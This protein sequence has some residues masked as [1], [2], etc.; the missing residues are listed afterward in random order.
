MAV[1][2]LAGMLCQVTWALAG[3]TGRISGTV[4]SADT[5]APLSNVRVV[6]SSPSQTTTTASDAS[7]TF[8]FLSLTPD[9]YTVSVQKEGYQA[10]SQSG[11]VVF[12]DATQTL[13]MRMQKE[14]QTIAHVVSQAAG[15]LVKS[16]TTADVYSINA[17]MQD[18]ISGLGGGG[19]LNSAYSAIASVPGAFVPLNQMGYFQTVHIRGGDYDQVGYELDGIPVNRSFDNYP[20]GAASSLGQQ[21]LQVYTGASPANSEGQGLAGYINQVIKSGT[22]PGFGNVMLGVGGP[23]FYHKLAVEAGGAAP[24]RLFSYYVGVGGYNQDFRYVDQNNGAGLVDEAGANAPVAAGKGSCAAILAPTGC[25]SILP[26]QYAF[27]SGIANRDVVL[28]VHFGLPHRNDGGH[29]DIQLLWDSG[30]LTNPFYNSTNDAGGYAAFGGIA[31]APTFLD[32]YQWTCNNVGTTTNTLN[33]SCVTPYL[34]PN[35]PSHQFGATIPADLRDFLRNT[36]GIVKVQFQKNMG[37]D[38][39]LRLYGYTY[40]S[41]WTQNGPNSTAANYVACC[42]SD[43]ELS[44]HT[45]GLSATLSDQASAKHL[46]TLQG[47]YTT[48]TSVRDNNTQFA[49]G[50]G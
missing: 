35:V 28:N 3:T 14:L 6:A 49:N 33:A 34:F 12:A 13:S 42:A 15:S 24:N 44:S 8:T 22:F 7:G 41:R 23:A 25:Y 21:E 40:Y 5:G 27:Q 32:G 11:V 38:A 48:A 45:R 20:S 37:S 26:Y 10:A 46:L 4:T 2:L 47:S 1:L 19:G 36:Q 39:Y 50:G 31:N 43:Y 29:D 16:G 17:S 9:T 18:K 30:E